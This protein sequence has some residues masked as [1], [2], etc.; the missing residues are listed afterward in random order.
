MFG[1]CHPPAN[2]IDPVDCDT[3][4]SV[5][6]QRTQ[7]WPVC[8]AAGSSLKLGIHCCSAANC[9]TSILPGSLQVV[10]R[11]PQSLGG[12][13]SSHSVQ[14]ELLPGEEQPDLQERLLAVAQV[15]SCF[16]RTACLVQKHAFILSPA[17]LVFSF[18]FFNENLFWVLKHSF[19]ACST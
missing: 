14:G 16:Q 13:V 5:H 12:G 3:D 9:V 17:S 18:F 2:Q 1:W 7:N 8:S 10:S 4:G 6:L 19:A 15:D 11:E